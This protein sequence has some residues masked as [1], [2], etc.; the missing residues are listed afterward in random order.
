AAY[1]RLSSSNPNMQ[2]QPARDE[3]IGPMWRS[4]YL[5]EEGGLWCADDYSQQ[6]P[7]W[8]VHWAVVAGRH[9]LISER[10][11]KAALEAAGKYRD[12]PSTD[13]HQMM[14]DMA[15]IKRKDAKELFLG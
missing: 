11:F 9:R 10:A 6:E 7:R 13:N 2:Q 3:E 14:A 8:L 4:I 12:D 15:G 5:P 1:G